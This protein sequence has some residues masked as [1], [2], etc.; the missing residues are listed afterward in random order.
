MDCR[1]EPAELTQYGGAR[2]ACLATFWS[3][4]SFLTHYRGST[5]AENMRVDTYFSPAMISGWE[6]LQRS[7]FAA[8]ECQ[9]TL[10]IYR[11]IYN[12]LAPQ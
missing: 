11:V 3:R 2:I 5:Y 1:F 4:Q 6:V 12:I 10:R 7:G 9:H 8:I